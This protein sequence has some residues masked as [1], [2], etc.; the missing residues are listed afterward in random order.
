MCTHR[1]IT[2]GHRESSSGRRGRLFAPQHRFHR[3]LVTG[4]RS[5][6]VN[7]PLSQLPSVRTWWFCAWSDHR[8]LRT[9]VHCSDDCRRRDCRLTTSRAAAAA[10]IASRPRSYG[11]TLLTR[12]SNSRPS[13]ASTSRGRNLEG[14]R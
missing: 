8:A 2:R 14:H 1:Q 12:R 10:R 11:H 3:M 5:F 6:E 7:D 9:C 4:G 13:A